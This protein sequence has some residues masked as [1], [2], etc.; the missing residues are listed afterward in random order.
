MST[1]WIALL[2]YLALAFLI[3]CSGGPESPDTR[4]ER[5]QG[6]SG[7]ATETRTSPSSPEKV[8]PA[9]GSLS[10]EI[11]EQKHVKKGGSIDPLLAPQYVLFDVKAALTEAPPEL[12]EP[13]VK[14]TLA[15]LLEQVR[16]GARHRGEQ[17]DGVS[18]FLYQ[19]Q[20][21]ITGGSPPLGRVEW[22]PKGHTFSPDNVANIENKATY[23]DEMDVFLLP[24]AA[25]TVVQRLS[26]KQRRAI[27][28]DLVQAEDRA[29][30]EAETMHPIDESLL[31]RSPSRYRQHVIDQADARVKESD[32]LNE[33]YERELLERHGLT[34][35]ELND[36][37]KEAMNE[38]WPLP[39]H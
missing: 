37:K 38:Q 31:T 23:V 14:A 17:I 36:I 12:S 11:V 27:F 3:G 29:M 1:R 34:K 35:Q 24:Q 25:E 30:R 15:A 18:A 32:R 10:F 6:R 28:T 13:K 16:S 33:K 7:A 5:R 8:V 39:P 26:E 4:E 22:W 20:E 21:H 19:S 9:E 2:L